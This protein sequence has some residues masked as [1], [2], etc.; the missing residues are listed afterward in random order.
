MHIGL[1][2]K[3]SL[4]NRP[5]TKT[6][7]GPNCRRWQKAQNYHSMR[8]WVVLVSTFNPRRIDS[9]CVYKTSGRGLELLILFFPITFAT[10]PSELQRVD[11]HNSLDYYGNAGVQLDDNSLSADYYS[12]Q[13][14]LN[15]IVRCMGSRIRCLAV[16]I[17]NADHVIGTIKD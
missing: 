15:D 1:N 5:D 10:L 4:A 14:N 7:R 12:M 3:L 16:R 6:I 13:I 8:V 11:Y 2:L 9:A 17:R